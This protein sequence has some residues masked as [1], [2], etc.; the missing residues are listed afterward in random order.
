MRLQA[1]NI[2]DMTFSWAD[3]EKAR[4]QD[5]EIERLAAKFEPEFAKAILA[6]LKGLQEGVDLET[7]IEALKLGDVEKVIA[8]LAGVDMAAKQAAVGSAIQTAVWGGAAAEAINIAPQL[9]G[10]TFAFNRLNLNLVSFLRRYELDLIRRIDDKTREAIRGSLITGMSEGSNPIKTARDVREAIGLT[11]RQQKAVAAYRKELET[12]HQKRTAKAWGIGQ[13]IDRVNGR[14][15]YRYGE[16]GQPMD[17]ILERRLRDFRY[18]THLQRALDTKKPIPPERIDKMVEAYARKYLRYRSET[19]ARTE[20]LRATNYGVQEAWRQVVEAGKASEH[21]LRRF[22][23]VAKDERVCPI[24]SPIPGMNRKG[25]KFAQPFATPKGP[26]MLPTA[27][28]NCRCTVFIRL[29]EPSQIEG[30]S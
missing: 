13:K 21:L 26:I 14:Q 22:W 1:E 7:L 2:T 8:A 30:W 23:K 10:V 6:Y 25:V 24:C 28:P 19:I 17:G 29:M 5:D 27:H 11:P 18:D 15:V 12:F 4:D 9:R 3:I 16:D 20:S